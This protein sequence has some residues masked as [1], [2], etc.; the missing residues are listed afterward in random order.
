MGS[1][2]SQP[3]YHA[4]LGRDPSAAVESR[5]DDMCH[6]PGT[7]VQTLRLTSRSLRPP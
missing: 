2:R 4:S 5:Q 6:P 3:A 7:Q 1:D